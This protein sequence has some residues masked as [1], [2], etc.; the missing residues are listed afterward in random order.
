MRH[1]TKK[2]MNC[3]QSES[4]IFNWLKTVS[5]S[6]IVWRRFLNF[7]FRYSDDNLWQGNAPHLETMHSILYW[8]YERPR[9]INEFRNATIAIITVFAIQT[10]A[11]ALPLIFFSFSFFCVCVL[12]GKNYIYKILLCKIMD[13]YTFRLSNDKNNFIHFNIFN[14]V[15]SSENCISFY[16]FHLWIVCL[17]P[18]LL[19]IATI[20]E[21]WFFDFRFVTRKWF[22]DESLCVRF[23]GP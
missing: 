18:S 21:S 16:S 23:N 4:G 12:E 14:F 17:S 7:L 11:L 22:T 8:N 9:L 13:I 19:A 5:D 2:N 20:A 15:Q 10:D 3:E 1:E 6:T